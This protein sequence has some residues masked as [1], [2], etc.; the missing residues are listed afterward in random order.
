[1]RFSNRIYNACAN[2]PAPVVQGLPMGIVLTTR[3]NDFVADSVWGCS[4]MS[5]T[6]VVGATITG[7]KGGAVL[8]K[9]NCQKSSGL[10]R[11]ADVAHFF[12]G[13]GGRS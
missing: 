11:R 3:L 8:F 12:Y 6:L 10:T 5:H 13:S 7:A 1:M 4:R 9:Q 2:I